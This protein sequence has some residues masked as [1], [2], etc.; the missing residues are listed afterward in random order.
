MQQWRGTQAQWWTMVHEMELYERP[1]SWSGYNKVVASYKQWEEAQAEKTRQQEAQRISD[2]A[3]NCSFM[4]TN[5][6]YRI[7]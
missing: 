5:E 4:T 6:I 7:R 1:R 3:S 2:G